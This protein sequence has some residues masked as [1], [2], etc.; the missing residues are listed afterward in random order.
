MTWADIRIKLAILWHYRIRK[1]TFQW[2]LCGDWITSAECYG[3][4]KRWES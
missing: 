1:H 3:C 4:N 2:Y